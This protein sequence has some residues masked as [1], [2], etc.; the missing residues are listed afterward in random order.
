MQK[1]Y[2]FLCSRWIRIIIRLLCFRSGRHHRGF[3][4]LS[5]AFFYYISL[6][7]R[8]WQAYKAELSVPIYEL[9]N[10]SISWY[11]Y[12]YG[13]VTSKILFPCDIHA[14]TPAALCILLVRLELMCIGRLMQCFLWVC[15][16][17]IWSLCY[18]TYRF[19]L[20]VC[21]LILLTFPTHPIG[22]TSCGIAVEM[23]NDICQTK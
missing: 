9:P 18:L 13:I 17:G 20:S 8:K 6:E 22:H 16:R 2:A 3:L 5:S 10:S 19:P 23:I 7:L 21:S 14:I 11:C 4:R 1:K 12:W 15:T